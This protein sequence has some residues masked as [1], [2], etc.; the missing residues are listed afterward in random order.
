MSGSGANW[1]RPHNT[2]G[3]VSPAMFAARCRQL[4]VVT[5]HVIA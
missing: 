2:L 3:L 1:S 5:A 4:A